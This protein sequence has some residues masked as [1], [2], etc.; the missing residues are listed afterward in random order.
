[1]GSG[2]SR[3]FRVA[4]AA[5]AA[6]LLAFLGLRLAGLEVAALAAAGLQLLF[7]GM[8]VGALLGGRR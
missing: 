3:V 2:Q 1:M 5:W 4:F 8:E 7:A 6:S